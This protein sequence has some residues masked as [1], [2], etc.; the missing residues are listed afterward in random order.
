[1]QRVDGWSVQ[2][3]PPAEQET[4]DL[5]SSPR[6]SS[7]AKMRFQSFFMLMAIQP[8]FFASSKS[9]WVKVP[10]LVWGN[11]FAGP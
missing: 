8:S 11:P 6:H 1:M 4:W 5:F 10:T 2:S 9:D 7:K 3:V